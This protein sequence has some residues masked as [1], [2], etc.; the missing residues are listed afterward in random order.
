MAL[1]LHQADPCRRN[2]RMNANGR[3]FQAT[4]GQLA[5]DNRSAPFSL[6]TKLKPR[7]SR[8]SR[9]LAFIRGS[10]ETRPVRVRLC[11]T[12]RDVRASSVQPVPPL[13]PNDSGRKLLR[14][15]ACK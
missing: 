8:N 13:A 9:P 1:R 15:D 10:T 7:F 6:V 14:K 2:P 3:E 11:D 4:I 12:P 5:T